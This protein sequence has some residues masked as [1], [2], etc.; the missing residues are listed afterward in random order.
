[1]PSKSFNSLGII[2]IDQNKAKK[3]QTTFLENTKLLDVFLIVSKGKVANE[4]NANP[5]MVRQI[6]KGS[7]E[8]SLTK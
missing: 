4:K 2:E 7:L 5:K 8:A 3:E 1:M 6:V